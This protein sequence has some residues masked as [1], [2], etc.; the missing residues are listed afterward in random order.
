MSTTVLTVKSEVTKETVGE[1]GEGGEG[2]GRIA[3]GVARM[4][5][6]SGRASRTQHC[7]AGHEKGEDEAELSEFG[8]HLC[9]TR[10]PGEGR[11]PSWVCWQGSR[12]SPDDGILISF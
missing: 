8:D 3:G 7:R 5:S 1:G 10:H 12:P 6:A 2:R 9:W 11:D 4:Q